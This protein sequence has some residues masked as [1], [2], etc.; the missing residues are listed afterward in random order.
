MHSHKIK[1]C[2]CCLLCSGNLNIS[3]IDG[4]REPRMMRWWSQISS[5]VVF[6]YIYHGYIFQWKLVSSMKQRDYPVNKCFISPTGFVWS[7]KD[8]IRED[9]KTELRNCN[10]FIPNNYGKST[11]LLGSEQQETP[12]KHMC[13]I[14]QLSCIKRCQNVQLLIFG[15]Q[16]FKNPQ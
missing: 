5:I 15:A 6:F 9:D 11:F 4:R 1:L 16:G 14:W 3:N 2:A 12:T 8:F 13:R 10:F 7:L